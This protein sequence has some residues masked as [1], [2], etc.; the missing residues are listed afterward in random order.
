M[1]RNSVVHADP[2]PSGIRTCARGLAPLET[3]KGVTPGPDLD[4]R[5]LKRPTAGETYGGSYSTAA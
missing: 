1:P 2:I 5:D 3:V 4:K